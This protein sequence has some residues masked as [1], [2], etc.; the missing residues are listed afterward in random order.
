MPTQ[1]PLNEFT[2]LELAQAV[3]ETRNII[4][5]QTANYNI[6]LQELENRTKEAKK[7]EELKAKEDKGVTTE[8]NLPEG[9]APLKK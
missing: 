3:I 7:L 2:D 5:M 9:A 4:D 1:K 6:I 8:M